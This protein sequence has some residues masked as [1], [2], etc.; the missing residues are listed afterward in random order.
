MCAG[1]TLCVD[2]IERYALFGFGVVSLMVSS[3]LAGMKGAAILKVMWLLAYLSLASSL[4][5]STL[6]GLHY[7]IDRMHRE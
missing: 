2:L 5:D 3:P 4:V 6:L 7:L 1:L